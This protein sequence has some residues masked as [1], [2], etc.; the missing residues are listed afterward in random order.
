MEGEGGLPL[1]L[2][3]W[4]TQGSMPVP[5]PSLREPTSPCWRSLPAGECRVQR[6]L[7]EPEGSGTLPSSLQTPQPHPSHLRLFLAGSP[8]TGT[9]QR[10]SKSGITCLSTPLTPG[11]TMKIY[12][13]EIPGHTHTHAHT[14]KTY[15]HTHPWQ[16]RAL[17]RRCAE[18][19]RGAETPAVSSKESMQ[20][21]GVHPRALPKLRAQPAPSPLHEHTSPINKPSLS[22]VSP[23]TD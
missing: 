10:R 12:I 13:Q 20:W 3:F 11:H 17:C 5:Q 22:L 1:H 21:G 16:A 4:A 23:D 18:I 6:R 14:H 15:V 8:D 19:R 9:G 2:P 7:G